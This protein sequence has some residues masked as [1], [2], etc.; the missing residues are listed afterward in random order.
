MSAESDRPNA[1]QID[2]WNGPAG[3]AWVSNQAEMDGTLAGLVEPLLDAADLAEGMRAVDVG[4]GCGA[5]TLALRARLGDGGHATGVDVSAAMLAKSHERATA[6]GLEIDFLESDAS[7]HAFE[8]NSIDRIVSRF[9]VMFFDRPDEAFANLRRALKPDGK[10]VFFCWQARSENPWMTL[11]MAAILPI[12][13]P[14][15]TAPDPY[16]PGPFS[17]GERDHLRGVLQRAGF[18]EMSIDDFAYPMNITGSLDDAVAFYTQRGP[19]QSLFLEADA[20]ARMRVLAVLREILAP[21]HDGERVAL[22]GN[23]YLVTAAP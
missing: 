22:E 17:L 19:V 20:D 18:G 13:A 4:C 3:D 7:A 12:L 11:P 15:A 6:D 9:G 2:Y 16:A 21:H 1:A 23:T 10:L 5:T 14:D 8:P